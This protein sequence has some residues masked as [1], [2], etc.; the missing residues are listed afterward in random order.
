V[1]QFDDDEVVSL[2]GGDAVSAIVLAQDEARMLGRA[3]VEPE[4]LLLAILRRG[5]VRELLS[6]RLAAGDVCA[7]VVE[8][9]GLGEEFVLGPVRRSRRLDEVLAVAL[10]L[11][12]QRGEPQTANEHLLLA[13]VGDDA[14]IAL[15]RHFGLEDV[16]SLVDERFPP[17]ENRLREDLARVELVR[18]ALGEGQRLS[19]AAV[20]AFERF[21][22]DARR[23]IRAAAESAASLEHREVDPFHLLIGCVQVPESFASRVLRPIWEDGELGSVG[24]VLDLARRTGPHPFHQATGIFSEAARGVVAEGALKLAYRA[25]HQQITTGHLLLATLDSDDRTTTLMT[26]PHTQQ[27]ARTLARGLPGS[28]P[29]P[30]EGELTWIQFDQLIRTLTLE[31]R[32]ILP[33]GWTVMGSARSDIH[34]KVPD[35]RSESDFQ[36]RPGWITAETGQVPERL[37]RVTQWMLERL[38]AA[39][40]EATRT[41]W[42]ETPDHDAAPAHAELIPDRYNPRLRLGY[43]DPQSPTLAVLEHDLLVNML[44]GT[45]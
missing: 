15:L 11:A 13:L 24:E 6:G 32:R 8:R 12:S 23:A 42:P 45:S 36:I 26:S 37:Q 21:T 22:G 14:V 44:T 38:Q 27:L 35:S 40:I 10:G 29:G 2:F 7:A 18:A 41:P 17:R 30:D 1:Q 3:T 43:G 5:R 25:G 20:P 34:L 31:F 33:P 4:H 9:A 39:V 19:Q 28:D 16:E